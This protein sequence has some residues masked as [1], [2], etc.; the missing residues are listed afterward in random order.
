MRDQSVMDIKMLAKQLEVSIGTV[1]RALNDRKDVSP[2]TRE[3]VL[4]AA[5][6]HGYSPNQFGR[7]LRRG[8]SG[9]IGF[10]LTL[11]HDSAVHGNPFFMALFEGIKAGL[12]ASGMDLLVLLGRQGENPLESLRRNVSRG[13]ADGWLLSAAQHEDPRIDLLMTRGIPFVTLGRTG[14]L[15]NH[16]WI[17]VDFE[18]L[19]HDALS[20]FLSSGHRRIGLIAPPLTAHSSHVVV[21]SYHAELQAADL[22]FDETLV[23]HGTTDEPGGADAVGLFFD[24]DVPPTAILVMGETA[25]VGVYTALRARGIEPGR[26]V[27][28]IGQRDNPACRMLVPP[29]TCFSIPLEDIG[30]RMAAAIL[31]ALNPRSGQ[32]PQLVQ[33]LWRMDVVAGASDSRRI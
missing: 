15:Y 3:R 18:Q 4:A 31:R 33:K 28:V 22:P 2:A 30:Q 10:M 29:L 7:G 1:S 13:V 27:A 25:P 5:A 19:V 32:Q 6:E 20:R 8:R 16:A 21:D 14:S 17:D 12:A 26:D 11:D 9:S 23:Y 24:L